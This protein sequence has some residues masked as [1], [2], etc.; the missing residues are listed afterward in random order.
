MTGQAIEYTRMFYFIDYVLFIIITEFIF[1]VR[2]GDNQK[3]STVILVS[4][5]K[6]VHRNT[7]GNTCELTFSIKVKLSLCLTNTHYAM[8]VYGGVDV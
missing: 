1:G 2:Q 3:T 4:L 5:R 6:K 8:K 7:D